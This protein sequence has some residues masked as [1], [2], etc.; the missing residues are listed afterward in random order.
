[1]VT[2]DPITGNDYHGLARGNPSRTERVVLADTCQIIVPLDQAEA[3][4][5]RDEAE[6]LHAEALRMR[7]L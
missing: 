7:E 6:R 2:H 1:V 5:Q 3:S 4:R